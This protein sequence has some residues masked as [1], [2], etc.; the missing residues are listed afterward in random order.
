M[1]SAEIR[2]KIL[3]D[4][5]FISEEIQK[6]LTYYQL[7]HMLRWTHDST[8]VDEKE[9]VAEH[10]YGMYVLNDYFL[11][12]QEG[13]LDTKLVNDLIL[14]HDMAEALV[15]DMTTLSKTNAHKQ[16][17]K[18]A[19][20]QL[21][22]NAPNHLQDKL[23]EMFKIYEEQELPEAK[24]VKAIDKLEPLFQIL[25]NGTRLTF[26]K[27]PDRH[28]RTATVLDKYQQN[29]IKYIE[30]FP[31]ILKFSRVLSN[32]IKNTSYLHPEA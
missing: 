5:L 18:E 12:L 27:D 25:H 6:I 17:E 26:E 15:D 13:S 24:F 30:A 16:L 8:Q 14:W 19:E 22:C 3:N 32:E 1:I 31:D 23:G 11:P 2:D 29:R 9:S 20:S 4:D 10:V 28:A 21:V 7:K